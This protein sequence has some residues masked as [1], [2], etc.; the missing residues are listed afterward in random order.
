MCDVGTIAAE[1]RVAAIENW[2]RG[3]IVGVRKPVPIWCVALI[4]ALVPQCLLVRPSEIPV[5]C[6]EIGLQK[7]ATHDKE[8]F[9]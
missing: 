1:T 8:C 9:G 6:Q 2:R 7:L 5:P 4:T 3:H